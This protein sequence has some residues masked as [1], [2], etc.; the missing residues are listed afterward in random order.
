MC[1]CIVDHDMLCIT[2]V[3]CLSSP[4]YLDGGEGALYIKTGERQFLLETTIY[5]M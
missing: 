5:S 1:V 2:F 3:M 4:G